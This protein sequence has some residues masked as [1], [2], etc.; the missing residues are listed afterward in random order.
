[1]WMNT[2][3]HI[4]VYIYSS[5]HNSLKDNLKGNN[6]VLLFYNILRN[7]IHDYNNTKNGRG[8]KKYY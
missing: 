5:L 2:K 6:N 3:M 8:H 4:Y 1:M 7:K